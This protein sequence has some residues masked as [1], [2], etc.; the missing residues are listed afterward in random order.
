M[1][2][3]LLGTRPCLGPLHPFFHVILL[4]RHRGTEV[5]LPRPLLCG[6]PCSSAPCPLGTGT[7]GGGLYSKETL[8]SIEVYQ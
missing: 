8:G 3:H 7:P 2:E 6:H 1:F 4:R 5:P